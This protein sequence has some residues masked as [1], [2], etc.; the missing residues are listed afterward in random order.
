MSRRHRPAP[1]QLT[2]LFVAA[3]GDPPPPAVVARERAQSRAL[4]IDRVG[5][6]A[7][8]EGERGRLRRR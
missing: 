8:L 2:L 6:P 1:G 3:L 4:R 5:D 7:A